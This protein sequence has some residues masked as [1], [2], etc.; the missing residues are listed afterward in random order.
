MQTKLN[1]YFSIN[2]EYSGKHKK[3][4]IYDLAKSNAIFEVEPL[5]TDEFIVKKLGISLYIRGATQDY[6]FPA[7]QTDAAMPLLK[8]NLQK[9]IRRG[10]NTV[11]M[12]SALAIW[13]LDPI[14]LV[15]RL[16]II[17]IEDVCVM[18][19]YPVLIWLMMADTNYKVGSNTIYFVL[20]LV[21][22][23]C[24]CN[25]T[26]DN[27]Y[28]S[29]GTIYTHESL[30]DNKRHDV[31]LALYY[32]QKYG[33][34]KG[35]MEMLSNAISY[36]SINYKHIVKMDVCDIDC[37]FEDGLEILDAAV[38]YHPFPWILDNISKK[39]GLNKS[40]IQEFIW[41]SESAVNFR[42][43]HTIVKSENYRGRSEWRLIERQLDT[44]RSKI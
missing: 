35:D 31:L 17:C 9:A 38:D 21:N 28:V 27:S 32:R 42:K 24:N 29:N 36:Y 10:I 26:F 16:A 23:L 25:E 22:W 41:F 8:S 30:Q 15:R 7:L 3:C 5:A 33:G 34:M 14:E 43:L 1:K 18:D 12:A 6:E 37:D 4:F 44:E 13:Q 19:S 20:K 2:T 40:L 39:T 11:A